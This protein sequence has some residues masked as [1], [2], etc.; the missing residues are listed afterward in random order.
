MSYRGV[1]IGKFHKTRK[2]FS[3]EKIGRNLLTLR[4]ITSFRSVIE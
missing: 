3:K 1:G 2:D 4:D